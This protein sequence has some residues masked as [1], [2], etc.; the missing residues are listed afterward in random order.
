MIVGEPAEKEEEKEE[1]IFA[2]L[3]ILQKI[4]VIWVIPR[5]SKGV[6]QREVAWV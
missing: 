5:D 4:C 1:K 3:K 6:A 2:F